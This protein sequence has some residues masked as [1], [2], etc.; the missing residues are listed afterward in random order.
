MPDETPSVLAG[1]IYT[2][3]GAE[4]EF[5]THLTAARH[6]IENLLSAFTHAFCSRDA[7]ALGEL[8]GH[9]TVSLN[10]HVPSGESK[11]AKIIDWFAHADHAITQTITNISLPSGASAVLYSATYQNWDTRRAPRCTSMGTFTGPLNTG[12]Q[13]QWGSQVP[14]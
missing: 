13:A 4:I 5:R 11:P 8:T 10:A 14:V 2:A 3:A 7:D 12:P 9:V 6:H 1:H